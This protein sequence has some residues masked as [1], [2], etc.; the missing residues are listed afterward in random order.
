MG[1]PRRS[2]ASALDVWS[3]PGTGCSRLWGFSQTLGCQ[4]SPRPG[5]C[6]RD[7]PSTAAGAVCQGTT[8]RHAQSRAPQLPAVGHQHS[9]TPVAPGPEHSPSEAHHVSFMSPH[10]APPSRTPGLAHAEVEAVLWPRWGLS[11][12]VRPSRRAASLSQPRSHPSSYGKRLR[13]GPCAL[14]LMPTAPYKSDLTESSLN[15]V[16]SGAG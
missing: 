4:E 2:A 14:E 6:F 1:R 13:N 16:I 8:G 7:L 15:S 10:P 5:D 12:L 11:G 3:G 9:H